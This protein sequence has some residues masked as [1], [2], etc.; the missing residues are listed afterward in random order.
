MDVEIPHSLGR[1]EV[2]RR[3]RDNSHRIAAGIPGGMAEV[4]TSWPS[5]DRMALS[6]TALGQA[7]TGHV[8]IHD[9]KVVF[10]MILPPAL[11]FVQPIV[12]GAIRDQGQRLLAAPKD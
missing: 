1:D 12:E 8:D 2:R 4:K 7:I 5:E 10:H 3:F 11:G 6:V 9:H